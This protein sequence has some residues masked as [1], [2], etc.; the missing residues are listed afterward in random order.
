MVDFFDT[1]C[2]TQ[3]DAFEFGLIDPGGEAPAQ[4][5]FDQLNDGIALVQNHHQK[6]VV[7]TAIDKCIDIA[8]EDKTQASRCDGMLTTGREIIF[9]ELKEKKADWIKQ[10]SKQV[11]ATIEQFRA[12]HNLMHDYDD[13][14]A[15]LCNNRAKIRGLDASHLEMQRR[16]LSEYGVVLKI[17]RVIA[18]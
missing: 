12:S 9:V 6:A 4:L 13:R 5:I 18:L 7:F 16:F 11:A 2:Q 1:K 3:T 17:D 10:A 14:H 8:R 15:Y